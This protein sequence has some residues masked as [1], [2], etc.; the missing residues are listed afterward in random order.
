M[1]EVLSTINNL[2]EKFKLCEVNRQ[3]F[4]EDNA[5]NKMEYNKLITQ[6]SVPQTVA[7]KIC[8]LSLN[9]FKEKVSEAVEKGVIPP[10]DMLGN[11]YLYTLN[12]LHALLDYFGA[13]KWGDDQRECIVLNVGNQ[14]GGTGKT[15]TLVNLS[16]KL[17]LDLRRRLRVL[18][19]DLDP[20][21]SIR[22]VTVSS[23]EADT[24]YMMTAVDLMLSDTPHCNELY[25]NALS[26]FGSHSE[27]VKASVLQTHIPNVDVLPA[28]PEDERFSEFAFTS[29][30]LNGYLKKLNDNVLAHLVDDYDICLIDSG[31]HNNPL[32]WSA[33]EACNGL[34][35]PV[36][37][38]KLD[39]SSTRTYVERLSEKLS[40]LPSKGEK[41]KFFKI[42]IVNYDDEQDRDTEMLYQIKEETGRSSLTA[43]IKRSSA[44]E[45]AARQ[46][47]SVMDLNKND[48]TCPA[49]QID[50]ATQS[51][52]DIS[53][54]LMLTFQES[55][56]K[57]VR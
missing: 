23:N 12:H 36:S 37:P 8:G 26:I 31:P 56:P 41:L 49:R 6:H 20:Q 40:Q 39:W 9:N 7:A 38:R 29:G 45:A 5:G 24:S 35:V 50:K 57:G 15:S 4:M 16:I 3:E 10:A 11:R 19:I 46:Y 22:D 54:E 14:K 17:A 43:L 27:V 1:N 2:G 47:C 13:S 21:G 25:K 51:L 28:F 42:G 53:T 30:D 34:L 18:M 55:F 52:K 44:F 48:T 33:L 32:V